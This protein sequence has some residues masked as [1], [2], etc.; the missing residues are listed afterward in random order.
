MIAHRRQECLLL[1]RR[2]STPAFH[3]KGQQLAL[4]AKDAKDIGYAVHTCKAQETS[5]PLVLPAD[6]S[7]ILPPAEHTV[8]TQPG[9]TVAHNVRFALILH[10]DLL[11][12]EE[13]QP[14]ARQ[15]AAIG[16]ACRQRA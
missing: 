7:L 3:L 9:E 13:R 11:K 10:C 6:G 16:R 2:P 12:L 15:A 1:Q 4:R 14:A 5:F 8:Q